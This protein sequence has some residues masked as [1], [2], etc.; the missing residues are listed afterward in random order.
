MN[1]KLS[2]MILT[3]LVALSVTA[4]ACSGGSNN[5]TPSPNPPAVTATP[6]PSP[7]QTP[8]VSPISPEGS[9]GMNGDTPGGTN[10]GA[11]SSEG[12]PEASPGGESSATP[13]GAE[14][15]TMMGVDVAKVITELEKLSEVDT[16]TV[17][18]HNGRAIV[19]LQ[20]D[21]QYQGTLT[22]R[23]E[24]MVVSTVSSVEEMLTDVAVTA[25]PALIEQI[26]TL[27]TDSNGQ[28]LTT[29]QQTKFDELYS[30]IKPDKTTETTAP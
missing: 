28:S 29:E 18:A 25:D 17:V 19:G 7:V 5:S 1:R 4:C 23:I 10:E 11:S 13:G 27:A 2:I 14:G 8:E 6:L 24:E 16:A 15:P 3:T 26:R 9:P 30:K 20:F 12:M 22:E 21:S